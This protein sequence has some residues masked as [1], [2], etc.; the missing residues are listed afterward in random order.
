MGRSIG[1][2]QAPA[3]VTPHALT[4]P[5]H[6][7]FYMLTQKKSP[8]HASFFFFL[9]YSHGL[10]LP[11]TNYKQKTKEKEKGIKKTLIHNLANCILEFVHCSLTST[12]VL[13]FQLAPGCKLEP[14]R[15]NRS[16]ILAA[17]ASTKVQR[18]MT[19]PI[20]RFPI[21]FSLSIFL[22]S[23]NL[24]FFLLV[25]PE[26][27]FQVPSKCKPLPILNTHFGS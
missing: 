15:C 8:I 23:Y 11:Q 24:T 18:V 14:S 22:F 7:P 5:L 12:R 1:P 16:L 25:S 3:R 19:Q 20:V 17:M 26:L 6:S 9:I 2:F 10:H 27:D 13:G 4:Y 21:T